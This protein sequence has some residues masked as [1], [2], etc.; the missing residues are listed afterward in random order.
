MD[1]LC[2][3]RGPCESCNFQ[4]LPGHCKFCSLPESWWN[5]KRKKTVPQ[6]SL[7][8]YCFENHP[9]SLH[10]IG[11]EEA[12]R[13]GGNPSGAVFMRTPEFVKISNKSSGLTIHGFALQGFSDAFEIA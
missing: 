5:V 3:S 13:I 11:K 10:A 12:K 9:S 7:K 8:M 2:E 1:K 6:Y 4:E